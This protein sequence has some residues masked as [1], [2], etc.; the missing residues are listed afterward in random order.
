MWHG[1]TTDPSGDGSA[2]QESND[3]R[4][5]V[6]TVELDQMIRLWTIHV[7]KRKE[8]FIERIL[9]NSG[10]STIDNLDWLAVMRFARYRF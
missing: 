7:L 6:I 8:V 4:R 1:L 10:G 2:S 5:K 3:L 9:I